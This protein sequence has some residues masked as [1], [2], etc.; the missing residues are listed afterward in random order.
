MPSTCKLFVM[1]GWFNQQSDACT[2]ETK[3]TADH[4]RQAKIAHITQHS[5]EDRPQNTTDAVSQENP[6]S[7]QK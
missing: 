6:G 4:K 1:M 3:N 7:A 2:D 5:A